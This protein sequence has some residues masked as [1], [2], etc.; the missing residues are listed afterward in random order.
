M[1]RP[2]IVNP[3]PVLP[4]PSVLV[5]VHRAVAEL[6]RGGF[7]VMA[8]DD[9]SAALTLAAEAATNEILAR[10]AQVVGSEP[11]LALTG[12]RA[13]VLG[14]ADETPGVALIAAPARLTAAQVATLADPLDTGRL[15]RG[16]Q[17]TSGA[18]PDWA[19]GAVAL[20]KL[21]R[22]LPAALVAPCS[23][24]QGD[25]FRVQ[26]KDVLTYQ[27][28]A[29]RSLR[30]V[31]EGRVPLLGAESARIVAFRPADGGIEHL[32]IIVGHPDR[33]GAVLARLHSEC[34]TGDLLGSLRCDCGNQLRGA[35]AELARAGSGVLLYL[36]QEG[37]GIGLVN[38]LRAYELQDA[39]FD[40]LDANQQLGFDDDERIYLP[41][42]E[43]LRQLGIR[44]VR[45]MTNN[46][47][48]VAGLTRH[49][50]Q[51]TERVPHIFPSNGHNEA[52]L[53]TKA[54]RS[55]HLF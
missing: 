11:Q 53:R 35:I 54:T 37:R 45:L 31:A 4:T 8:A 51:V 30:R 48:K 32:A 23:G 28:L 18:A 49:G 14:L 39:G 26:V 20:A 1:S 55:G 40:T 9:G 41:A 13:A 16:L 52:Y 6:R 7:V 22:M 50:V 5:S 34:F 38:K 12:R 24:S 44:Q 43:M 3:R 21:A 36:A 29:A 27:L 15:D 46:P 33:D 47:A 25:T 19:A 2:L 17:V 42:A 10:F